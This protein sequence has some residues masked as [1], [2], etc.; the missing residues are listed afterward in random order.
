MRMLRPDAHG[1]H[2]LRHL[3]A[4]SHAGV[5]TLG[6]DVGQAIVDDDLDFDVRVVPAATS[7]SFGQRI[8]SAA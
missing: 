8:V 1:D 7:C 3:L 2:V 4:D 5:E 6:D